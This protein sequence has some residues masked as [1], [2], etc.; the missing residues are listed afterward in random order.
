MA[1]TFGF[2]FL[3][4]LILTLI[5]AA[6]Y[7]LPEHVRFRSI[8]S[9]DQDRGRQEDF[10]IRWP[11]DRIELPRDRTTAVPA[12]AAVGAAV[13]E[14]SPGVRASAELFRVRDADGNVI[15]LAA[16][17]AGVG[18]SVSD[19]GNST[20]NWTLVIPS[21]GA[22]LLAA[23]DGF[24]ATARVQDPWIVSATQSADAWRDRD[25]LLVTA[26]SSGGRGTLVRGTGEFVDLRGSYSETWEPADAA[27]ADRSRGQIVLSTLVKRD[28]A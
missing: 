7:P 13:L 24:D 12:I 16:R 20:S 27:S 15:G 22:M 11:D 28:G 21:R 14:P 6:L 2:A 18:G 25:K 5:G 19:P 26:G 23:G 9:V 4:G 10:L 1:R 8:T 3:T 17:V